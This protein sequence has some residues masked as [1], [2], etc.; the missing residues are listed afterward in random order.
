MTVLLAGL[1]LMAF[2]IGFSWVVHLVG[3]GKV[4]S[5]RIEQMR[6]L[7]PQGR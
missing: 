2:G 1:A 6:D 4:E 7:W 3:F 5:T